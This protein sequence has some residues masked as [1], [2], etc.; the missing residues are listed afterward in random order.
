MR[1]REIEARSFFDG[2]VDARNLG[3]LR[4]R[5][6]DPELE[7]LLQREVGLDMVAVVM[8]GE[9]HGRRPAGARDR[10]QDRR[11]LG[12]VDDRRLAASSVVHQ[13]AEIVAPAH[14]LVDADTPL[15]ALHLVPRND[16][17]P[18]CRCHPSSRNR[19]ARYPVQTLQS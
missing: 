2:F 16:R 7:P 6:D 8:R 10:G 5:A 4:L 9:D 18:S 1:P 14:E 11:L 19:F 13:D 15:N 12:R 17:V 3:R